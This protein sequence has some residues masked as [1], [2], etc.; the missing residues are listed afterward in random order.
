MC[1]HFLPQRP[2]GRLCPAPHQSWLVLPRLHELY[3][4][5]RVP[6][7][8][9]GPSLPLRLATPAATCTLAPDGPPV[10]LPQLEVGASQVGH[11]RLGVFTCQAVRA[12]AP[13]THDSGVQFTH[14]Q[15][16]QLQ[17]AGLHSFILTINDTHHSHRLGSSA[18]TTPTLIMSHQLGYQCV[19]STRGNA[20]L[21]TIPGSQL[22]LLIA[23]SPLHPHTEIC[24][25][26]DS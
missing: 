17:D 14:Q 19:N 8:V 1:R 5:H 22:P 23:L 21:V 24:I 9:H 2:L 18:P 25:V 10:S 15:V 7:V 20:K 16:A 11:V 3:R 12:G 4:V 13:L 26:P 6:R